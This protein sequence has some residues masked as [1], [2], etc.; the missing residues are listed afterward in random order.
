[1]SDI[2]KKHP[3]LKVIFAPHETNEKHILQLINALDG[4]CVRYSEIN[5]D[6]V[7][8]TN[9]LI[10]D[11]IGILSSVYRYGH[12]AYIG[13]G[14]GVGIHNILE[15]ATYGM[16][17]VFGPNYHKFK[18]ARDLVALKGA[19]PIENYHDI[20]QAFNQLLGDEN[21]CRQAGEIA[22]KFCIRSC[23]SNR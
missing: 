16:P 2:V 5:K 13:G 21:A 18:E 14:F 17:V 8:A 1:M 20:K 6:S 10:V 3:D 19:F 22:C 15:A 12:V 11:I 7:I 9:V 4:D 23:W